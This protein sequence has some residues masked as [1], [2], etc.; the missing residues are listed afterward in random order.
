MSFGPSGVRSNRQWT[1][2][3]ERTV[4]AWLT[5]QQ[6]AIRGAE[7]R[8][9]EEIAQAIVDELAEPKYRL[10]TSWW[11]RVADWLQ[12]A[13]VRFLEWAT[14]ISEYVG[15][16]VVL[17]LLVGGALVGVAVA[18]TANLG[19]RRARLVDERIRREHEAAR[20]LDP[21][22]LERRATEAEQN[23]D[24]AVALRLMFRAA[25]IRLDRAGMIDLRPGTTSGT[26]A[27]SVG[28][29]DF[30]ALAERFDAVV[31]GDAPASAADP[32]LARA[33]VAGI[34][35]RSPR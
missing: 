10:G 29:T 26:V 14:E 12:Q 23:G 3:V 34:L 7:G 9:R 25:L 31:Y 1:G 28:S 27:E 35:A 22:A 24:Y 15:G 11:S 5:W 16:P 33:A 13:W 17:A 30:A 32:E 6:V 21:V 19:H 4:L 20:G 2:R 8:S 18:V